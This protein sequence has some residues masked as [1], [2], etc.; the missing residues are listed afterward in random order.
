MTTKLLTLGLFVAAIGLAGCSGGETKTTTW[1]TKVETVPV[2]G[3]DDD[4]DHDE[5]PHGGTIIELGNYHGEFV[6]DHEK[7]QA[8]VYILDDAV[9]NPVA[10][11][12]ESLTLSIKSPA[13]TTELAAKPQESDPKGNSSRFVGTHE[14]LGTVQE[15]EG[16][17]SYK[18]KGK[19]FSGD[20]KEEAHED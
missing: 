10:I 11:P 8:T 5:G 9:K 14:K 7:E 18:I 12:A 19:P 13:F 3:D 4:H 17:V 6:V 16:S 15:F 1:T 20:F 2:E